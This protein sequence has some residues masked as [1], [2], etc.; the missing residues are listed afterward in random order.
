MNAV[1]GTYNAPCLI[2]EVN[3]E[4]PDRNVFIE[5][6]LLQAMDFAALAAFRADRLTVTTSFDVNDQCL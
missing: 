5:T 6:R 1:D 3:L 2:G 4:S